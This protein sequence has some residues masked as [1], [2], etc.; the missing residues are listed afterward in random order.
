M[1]SEARSVGL[2]GLGL[3]GGVFAGRLIRAGYEVLDLDI[4]P[5]RNAARRPA[6]A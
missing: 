5:G 2:I 6:G 4:D 3:M 1:R